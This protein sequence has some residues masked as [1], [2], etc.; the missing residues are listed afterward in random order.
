MNSIVTL[1]EYINN[2]NAK[3]FLKLMEQVDLAM[4]RYYKDGFTII[5]IN[6]DQITVDLSNGNV[7]FPATNVFDPFEKTIASSMTGISLSAD[8]KSS[9]EHN[10]TA[11]ALMILGWYVSGDN[12]AVKSDLEA[13]EN[14]DQFMEKTPEWIRPYFAKRFKR[15]EDGSFADYYQKQFMGKVNADIK[16]RFKEYDISEDMMAKCSSTIIRDINKD[17]KDSII[18]GSISKDSLMGFYEQYVIDRVPMALNNILGEQQ[19]VTQSDGMGNEKPL[20]RVLERNSGLPSAYQEPTREVEV[21]SYQEPVVNYTS[22]YAS[23]VDVT[24]AA[25][26][27][28]ATFILT[29]GLIVVVALLCLIVL[30]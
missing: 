24:K 8:R 17:I 12:S 19:D 13:L 26:A 21:L 20:T 2:G 11:F 25:F 29:I 22:S 23:D 7:I 5:D 28:V 3:S 4:E 18:N 10:Q 14:Y 16:K 6:L 1:R 27:N 9:R 15:L 30:P